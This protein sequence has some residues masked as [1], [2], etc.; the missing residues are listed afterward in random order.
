MVPCQV[1]GCLV[2]LSHL[3][4]YFNLAE[5]LTCS[6]GVTLLSGVPA[7]FLALS[8][9]I[10]R[11]SLYSLSMWQSA[12]RQHWQTCV[13]CG[14][15][16]APALDGVEC[17]YTILIIVERF[18]Y[19]ISSDKFVTLMVVYT[20]VHTCIHCLSYTVLIIYVGLAQARPKYKPQN[21]FLSMPIFMPW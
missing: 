5:S 4:K 16:H 15:W 11:L 20:P 6:P 3:N 14:K 1:H 17:Q 21:W 13:N 18:L 9:S 2:L 7:A 10:L 12:S 19:H 8:L